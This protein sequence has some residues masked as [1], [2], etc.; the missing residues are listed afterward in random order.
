[1]NEI[2]AFFSGRNIEDFNP[3]R[4][5]PMTAAKEAIVELSGNPL[6]GYILESLKS[7]HLHVNLGPEFNL[8]ALIRLLTRDGFGQHAKNQ[9]ELAAALDRAGIRSERKAV[10]G[11]R[12]RVRILPPREDGDDV[13]P[14]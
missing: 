11:Q 6:Y 8:D 13:A 2:Y 12:R 1:M 3:H 5:P 9:K 14:F 7:G 4:R 10:D